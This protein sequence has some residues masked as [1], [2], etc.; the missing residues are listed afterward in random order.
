MDADGGGRKELVA[1][2]GVL[3]TAWSPDGLWI[4]FSQT[5][6]GHKEDVFIVPASGGEPV[7]V[8]D[9]PNDDFQPRWSDD[10]KRLSFAS[11]TD[12]GQYTL[13]YIWLLK[14][15]YW[16]T[17]EEREKDA[18]E[19][20]DAAGDED[21]D[22]GDEDA[23][24]TVKIDLDR[25]N[26][27]AV[28]VLNMRG[29]YDFYAQTPD[30][31][32]YAFRDRSLQQDNLWLVDWKGTSLS[33]V[34]QGGG[35]PTELAWDNAGE[36]CYYIDGG[37]IASVS[38]DPDS[39]DVTGRGGVGF[40]ARVTVNIPEERKVMFREAWRLLW[41]GF[42]DADFHGVDWPAIHDKY[43]PLAMAAY[44][45]QEFR[46]VVREM[47][48]E[49]SAS[50]LGIYKYGGGGVSTGRL[51]IY[52]YENYD[53][54]GVRVRRVIPD[55]PAERAGIAAGDYILSIAGHE[56][57]PGENYNRPLEDTA[58]EEFLI[59]VAVLGRGKEQARGAGPSRGVALR[60]GRTRTASGSA[61]RRST[62]CPAGGSATCTSPAWA[63]ATCSSSRRTCSPRARARTGSSSTS[64]ATAA[65]PCTTRS[66]ATSTAA[67]TATRSQGAGRRP[68]TRSSSIRCR[69]RS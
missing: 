6:M 53:G 32:Y 54:P 40:S 8:T 55:G 59:E 33:Q 68:T 24:V 60:A 2:P 16:K 7:N 17:D 28:T 30:G 44:T 46:S 14:D 48:G 57:A 47:L 37:R 56:L 38:I 5:T 62:G 64:G 50:H 20:E 63:P 23:G 45:E 34:S 18:K 31:H 29:G 49:L 3:H 10:G 13:E 21:E 27:R 22:D 42:Y 51:G 67:P 66:S 26:E 43:E 19:A 58:G 36:T 39:G 65:G 41:N 15:D 35:D 1:E 11:R 25:I 9:H 52:H 69:S 61:G 12:D 4:A